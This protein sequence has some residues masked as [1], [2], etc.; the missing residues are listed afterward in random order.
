MR[1]PRFH[2]CGWLAAAAAALVLPKC[3]LCLAGYAALG[4]AAG[5]DL[6]GEAGEGSEI[7]AWPA[8]FAAALVVL[9]ARP[10]QR[11]PLVRNRPPRPST[12]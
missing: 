11:G 9:W 3:L 1:R 4:L 7:A 2:S 5:P 10:R 6:C 12:G 8:G